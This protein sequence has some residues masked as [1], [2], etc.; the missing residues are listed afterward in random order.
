MILPVAFIAIV[1]SASLSPLPELPIKRCVLDETGSLAPET[2]E[3]LQ[4]ICVSLDRI[5]KGQLVLVVVSDL[6]GRY[7]IGDLAV[8]LF[9]HIQLGHRDRDD[10]VI[11][12][13]KP[14][15]PG[16]TAL[17]ITIGYGLEGGL[18][19]ERLHCLIDEVTL[20]R[21][22]RGDLDGALIELA[23][24]LSSMVLEEDKTGRI[25]KHATRRRLERETET[26]PDNIKTK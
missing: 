24:K 8:D 19:D 9:R 2:L 18:T 16:K 13:V 14:G 25:E 15:A 1:A 10:G 5:Q 7:D 17:R 21:I 20:P 12:L 23:E 3:K 26:P 11:V 6:H 4:S 22:R